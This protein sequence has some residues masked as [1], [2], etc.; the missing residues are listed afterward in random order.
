MVYCNGRLRFDRRPVSD[1]F[2]FAGRRSDRTGRRL[3]S[4]MPTEAG[5]APLRCDETAG[6]DYAGAPHAVPFRAWKRESGR[7]RG[8]LFEERRR[9]ECGGLGNLSTNMEG[10]G[11]CLPA[12]SALVAKYVCE[13]DRT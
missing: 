9:R 13:F 6:Q 4:R 2:N 3:Y 12:P 7:G 8:N 1:L 5:G 10:A 11:E